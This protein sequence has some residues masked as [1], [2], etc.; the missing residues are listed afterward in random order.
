MNRTIILLAGGQSSR[1]GTNKALLPIEGE[2]VISRIAKEAG[3]I[4]RFSY[5][6]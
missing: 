4:D 2:T 5:R 3:R 6:A 1:M